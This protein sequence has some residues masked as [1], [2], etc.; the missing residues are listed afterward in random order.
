MPEDLPQDRPLDS[1][2]LTLAIAA[3]LDEDLGGEPG[4]DVTTQATIPADASV[5]GD[6]VIRDEGVVA[7]LTVIGHTLGQVATRL[8]L[9]KPRVTI[10]AADGDRVAAGTT[11]AQIAGPGH[12]VLIAE[13]TILNFM[14][15]ACG[16]ATHTRLWVDALEG[17]PARVLDTRKTTPG[18]RELEKYAVRCGGGTN[19]RMGLFDCAMVKDNHIVAAGSVSGAIA[20]ISATYPGVPIQ[21]EV[22]RTSQAIEAIEAGVRFLMLDNMSLDAMRSLVSEVRAM[23]A[24]VGRVRLEA[25]GGLTLVNARDV[26]LTGVDFMSVGALTHSSPILD[27]ALDLH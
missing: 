3:A 10:L 9:P 12:V 1:A 14:S 21:V 24:K 19:K 27:V 20:A 26:A 5:T 4:R 18:L 16:I 23:E 2:W 11:V 25:T 22:E 13:R 15:R 7:G 8:G 6:V 17:T